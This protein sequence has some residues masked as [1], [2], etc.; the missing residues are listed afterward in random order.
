VGKLVADNLDAQVS[1]RSTLTAADVWSNATRTLSDYAT[2]STALAVWSAGTR[3]LTSYGND[4]T[5]ADVWNVLSSNLTL[6][7]SIGKQLAENVD[8]ATSTRASQ[9]SL[10]AL[11]NISATDVWSYSN[12]SITDP[13]AIWEYALTDIG[14]SGSIG[15]L[16]KDNINATISSRS[17]M[18]AADVWS[19][20]ERTLT[21]NANFNDP[22]SAAIASAVWAN[23]TRDLTN[24]G[25]DITAADV[26]NVLSSN[27]TTN[28]TIGKQLAVNVDA[29]VS[30]RSTLTAADVWNNSTRSLTTFGSLVSDIWG[31]SSRSLTTFGTL[32]A[33]IWEYG[34][35]RT[36]SSFGTLVAD[37]WGNT[38]RS[39]TNYG[40]DIAA[41]DV[42]NYLSQVNGSWKISMSNAQQILAGNQYRVKVY[43][44]N[45]GQS[46]NSYTAPLVTIYDV[47]RNVVVNSVAM[48]NIGTGIYEYVY[49][50]A[51]GAPQGI[52]ETITN[53]ETVS[54][55]VI[56]VSDYWE[57]RGSPAQVI[58]RGMS[59]T[60]IPQV[61][62]DVTITNEG[63]GGYEYLYEWCV[64]NN[65]NNACGGGD[66]V[67]YAS[68]AKFIQPGENWNTNLAA[69][70]ATTGPYYFKLVVYF[71]TESSGSSRSFTATT[72]QPNPFCGDN[73]CNNNETCSTCPGDCGQCVIP[74]GGGGG[75]GGG[76]GIINIPSP[77]TKS[78]KGADLNGDGKVNSID[79][80]ILLY[81]WK[82]KPPF[83]NQNVDINH[84]GK[85]DAVDFSIMLYQW[86]TAGTDVIK[87]K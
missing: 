29:T 80:S 6:Q 69:D 57:V 42:W 50:V 43:T 65:I 21:S 52:W 53:T 8:V 54:G 77:F 41:A 15:K 71:G 51:A 39:L 3:T 79:F 34:G 61:A 32:V 62:A 2:D 70:V 49:T 81:Y 9:A 4:I 66:D 46:A 68:G 1:S 75:G 60:T 85:V 23:A 64:V 35:G 19:V 28:G 33:D 11:N 22:T 17:N 45:N 76:A 38:T 14:N 7:N 12:R 78:P 40:N 25:N 59:D 73:I 5:A 74:G 87:K 18:T 44:S 86:G 31:Y 13:D 67:F 55:N 26:W 82:T 30:S 48:S 58:I 16:L 27:L 84:D 24:Y 83:K 36:L 10:D 63:S 56:T 72:G 20:T 47:N 37:V